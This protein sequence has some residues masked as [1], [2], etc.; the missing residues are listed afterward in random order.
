MARTH[1]LC[2]LLFV[3]AT[4]ATLGCNRNAVQQ[5]PPPD[6]LLISTPGGVAVKVSNKQVTDVKV[7]RAAREAVGPA[8]PPPPSLPDSSPVTPTSRLVP[9]QEYRD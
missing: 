6:P 5:K 2:G 3:L 9:L 8:Y 4:A 1:W 7:E